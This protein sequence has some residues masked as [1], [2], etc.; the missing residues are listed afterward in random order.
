MLSEDWPNHVERG[1][2]EDGMTFILPIQEPQATLPH[3]L[4]P[5]QIQSRSNILCGIGKGTIDA[6]QNLVVIKRLRKR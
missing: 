3:V 2:A 1:D 6:R 5:S 4:S